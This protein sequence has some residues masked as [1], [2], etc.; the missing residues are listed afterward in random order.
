MIINIAT[1]VIFPGHLQGG[2]VWYQEGQCLV[3]AQIYDLTFS[4]L[5]K[6][7]GNNM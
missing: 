1:M 5:K 3:I 6:I 7:R 4:F 2:E